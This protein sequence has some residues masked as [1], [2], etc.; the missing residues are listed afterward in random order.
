MRTRAFPWDCCL[1][2]SL[3][4]LGL[5]ACGETLTKP[6]GSHY[7]RPELQ[8][9]LTLVAYPK[10]VEEGRYLE[11]PQT[12]YLSDRGVTEAVLHLRTADRPAQVMAH[13]RK[14]ARAQGWS[15]ETA[16]PAEEVPDSGTVT[17]FYVGGTTTAYAGQLADVRVE[18]W[19]DFPT[20][21]ATAVEA[22]ATAGAAPSAWKIHLRLKLN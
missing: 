18:A 19:P 9:L 17:T 8:A 2:A 22:S 6:A 15:G 10:A 21:V 11:S 4:V 20:E 5:S 1:A 16:D 7:V 12:T 13:Y 14:L 3:L